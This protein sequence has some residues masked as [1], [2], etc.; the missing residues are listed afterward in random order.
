ME[1]MQ[2]TQNQWVQE[3]RQL[4]HA[5]DEALMSRLITETSRSTGM[6]VNQLLTGL[7]T[8]LQQPSQSQPMFPASQYQPMFNVSQPWA[9]FNPSDNYGLRPPTPCQNTRRPEGDGD[10]DQE[11]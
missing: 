10:D 8:V 6:L 7:G 11:A 9:M 5:R 4:S 1:R 2:Q 3:Q